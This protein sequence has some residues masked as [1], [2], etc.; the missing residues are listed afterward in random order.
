MKI[1]KNLYKLRKNWK[2]FRKILE[3]EIILK[4]FE[5]RKILKKIDTLLQG[6]ISNKTEDQVRTKLDAWWYYINLFGKNIHSKVDEVIVPFLTFCFGSPDSQ[7]SKD[8]AAISSPVKDLTKSPAKRYAAVRARCLEAT[9]V[10]YAGLD[11]VSLSHLDIGPTTLS[12]LNKGVFTAAGF[13]KHADLLLWCVSECLVMTAFH[14]KSQAANF[15][16]LLKAVSTLV[17]Q[18]PNAGYSAL[19]IKILTVLTT[20]F[21]DETKLETLLEVLGELR[22]TED[23]DLLDHL[24]RTALKP[25][26]VKTCFKKPGLKPKFFSVFEKLVSSHLLDPKRGLNRFQVALEALQTA[27]AEIEANNNNLATLWKA[28]A[29]AFAAHLEKHAEVNQGTEL[30]PDITACRSLLV[31]PFRCFN[32][33]AMKTVWKQWTAIYKQIQMN[34]SLLISYRPLELEHYLCEQINDCHFNFNGFNNVCQTLVPQVASVQPKD[35][36][37][38]VPILKM[39]VKL[40]TLPLNKASVTGH[41]SLCQHLAHLV[42]H[43]K[44]PEV[45]VPVLKLATPALIAMLDKPV[46]SSGLESQVKQLHEHMVNQFQ[47]RF[48]GKYTPELLEELEPFVA[49]GMRHFNRE[50]KTR[51]LQMWQL[52][53]ANALTKDQVPTDVRRALDDAAGILSSLDTSSSASPS[54]PMSTNTLLNFA[55][56]FDKTKGRGSTILENGLKHHSPAKTAKTPDKKSP[57]VKPKTRTN[58]R[59]S[60]EEEDSMDFVKIASPASTSKKRLLTEHQKDRMTSRHDDI[61][62]LYSELSR[63]DSIVALPLEFQS[64]SSHSLTES[65]PLKD[66]IEEAMDGVLG[67]DTTLQDEAVLPVVTRSSRRKSG[68]PKKN[69]APVMKP[70]RKRKSNGLKSSSPSKENSQSLNVPSGTKASPLK[71]SNAKEMTLRRSPRKA[72]VEMT[73]ISDKASAQPSVPVVE[74]P[75]VAR[76]IDFEKESKVI[77]E[78]D[79]P[80]KVSCK[81]KLEESEEEVCI[82]RPRK[83]SDNA[84]DDVPKKPL[85]LKQNKYGETPLHVAVRKSDLEKVTSLLNDV[86]TDVNAKDHAGWTPI[87]EAM[88][89]HPNTVAIVS[90]LIQ[91]GADVNAKSESG[92]TALHDAA[93]FL[94]RDVIDVLVAGGADINA[95]NVEGKTPVDIGPEHFQNDVEDSPDIIA[96]TPDVLSPSKRSIKSP[97]KSV[98]SMVSAFS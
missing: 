2:N 89:S 9:A 98:E 21:N 47:A 12:A 13:A 96:P 72:A 34:L 90:L 54:L 29:A 32:D 63:D 84:E 59:R 79:V 50:V 75:N 65:E 30:S 69:A 77:V 66:S 62:A 60:L 14:D 20:D 53:F 64:Q 76:K 81:R 45:I 46:F 42:A 19:T 27:A 25:D 56:V 92:S 78:A 51:T 6:A 97:S 17:G 39:M 40:A 24:I 48:Q 31:L 5:F 26:L 7:I 93:A 95:K 8:S 41:G 38:L 33:V 37:D 83:D 36:Q 3:K 61:P 94:S 10:L 55:G 80:P 35:L 87:H 74:T 70:G 22:R 1:W 28:L 49:A 68:T 44:D 11:D 43:L 91:K 71:T 18:T 88:R 82:K 4:N 52:T 57:F 67:K 15:T 86:N 58:P 85:K 73:K 16:S 23:P